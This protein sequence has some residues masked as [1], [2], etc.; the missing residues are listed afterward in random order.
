MVNQGT[1]SFFT[2]WIEFS[3]QVQPLG[4]YVAFCSLTRPNTFSIPYQHKNRHF[5]VTQ[6]RP[7]RTISLFKPH[8]RCHW[9]CRRLFCFLYLNICGGKQAYWVLVVSFQEVWVQLHLRRSTSSVFIW[10]ICDRC[11][12][13]A[14]QG[15][16]QG[17]ATFASK[18]DFV[19]TNWLS[20][21]IIFNVRKEPKNKLGLWA[22]MMISRQ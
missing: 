9:P 10:H 8:R 14:L 17:V 22:L 6:P 5:F 20:R 1:G 18:D 12:E 16:E 3:D 7:S 19:R 21:H 15:A 13:E 4:L 11:E 2:S